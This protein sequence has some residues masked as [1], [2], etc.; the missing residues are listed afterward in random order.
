MV[1]K[2]LSLRDIRREGIEALLERLGPA[3]TIR[4]L[5]DYDVGRGDYTAARGGWLADVTIDQ[6]RR[7][8]EQRRGP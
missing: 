3:G 4:F 1:R 8:I 5:Q 2:N 7:D 6:V